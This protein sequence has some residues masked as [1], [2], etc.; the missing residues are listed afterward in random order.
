MQGFK[1][2][3]KLKEAEN[4][5]KISFSSDEVEELDELNG[6]VKHLRNPLPLYKAIYEIYYKNKV[7]ELVLRIVG[8]NRVSGIYKILILIVE[9]AM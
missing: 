3:E 7:N 9:N 2:L 8:S 6:V 4:F 1:N 5:N